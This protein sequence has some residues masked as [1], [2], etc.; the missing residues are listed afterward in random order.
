M[1]IQT[2]S[3]VVGTSACDA[4]CPFCISHT[5]GFENLPKN[6]DIDEI[7]FHK[8]IKLAEMS[9]TTTV[10]LTGKGEPTLYPREIDWY[11][12]GLE[13][14][15]PFVELQTNAL[16]IGYLAAKEF[17]G[18][19]TLTDTPPKYLRISKSDL[20]MWREYGLTTIAIST[21]GIDAE[22]NA[23][24]Y[25]RGRG[26]EYYPDLAMTARYLH[27]LGYSVRLCVMMLDQMID[28]PEKVFQLAE[29]CKEAKIAQL[30]VR[31][32]RGPDPERR[33]D[34][35][36][37]DQEKYI[38]FHCLKPEQEKQIRDAVNQK[39]T[40][41]MTLMHGA[42]TAKVYDYNGQNICVS[43]CLTVEPSSDEIRTL[44]FYGDGKLMYDWQY[45][46][47]RLL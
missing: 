13:E 37:T 10:L 9:G 26:A 19:C 34:N 21:V 38:F 27:E 41:I 23:E 36:P 12:R 35:K 15:F 24:V 22:H 28:S 39:A 5:T 47:A 1:K 40:Q 25:L 33:K 4:D 45:D 7:N 17:S 32:I 11:L 42:H 31:P 14:R 8:A 43:D 46:G 6:R 2:F 3:I 20:V 16:Q 18:P 30:T 29:W 44:I